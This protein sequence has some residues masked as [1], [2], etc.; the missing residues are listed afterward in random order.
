MLA[1]L[2]RFAGDSLIYALMSVGTKIIAFIM[3]PFYSKALT[4]DEFGAL[5]VI[6]ST[7]SIISFLV[8]FGTDS[9]LAYYY[10]EAKDLKKKEAYVRNVMT[11]RLLV[12]GVMTVVFIL[13]GEQL[14]DIVANSPSFYFA[15]QISM[16][17]IILDTIN[18]LILTVLRFDFQSSRVAVLTFTKI[19]LIAAFAYL[20]LTYV[21]QSLNG[22]MYSRLLSAL[23]ILVFTFSEVW[24][25][26]RPQI[27]LSIWKEIL[28]YATPL[29]PAS[30]AFWIINSSNRYIV[31]LFESKAAATSVNAHLVPI[32]A[33][34]SVVTLF[35]Y[36]I[37]MAWR[38]Y[39]MKLKDREDAK[40]LFAKVYVVILALGLLAV[41]VITTVSPWLMSFADPEY[42]DGYK[43]I[44]FFSLAGFLNFFYLI[45][46]VGMF[47]QKKT[48][49]VTT[50]FLIASV[51]NLVLNLLLY[52]NFKIWGFVISNNI[53]YLF[54][55]LYL[56][57][58]SQSIYQVPAKTGKLG[59]MLLQAVLTIGAITYIQTNDL[60]WFWIVLSW[61]YFLGSLLL[62]RIDRDLRIKA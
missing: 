45:V 23:L 35:T 9:A 58:Y 62:I 49:K 38:P 61:L 40:E 19:A 42:W 29:V 8:I 44:G 53:T 18:V 52:P 33:F 43:Y 59:F 6:D 54:V 36:G 3:T 16:I 32:F 31:F 4:Q 15:L 21:D 48:G 56:Y 24:K 60:P 13:F 37:Q 2:K 57:R 12:A 14:S 27:D 7:L 1:Q 11:F 17:T 20:Y 34:A 10:M 41:I 26:V 51:L 47:I 50:A 39:S 25:Y 55:L 5:G 28:I 22:L 30:L 46:T